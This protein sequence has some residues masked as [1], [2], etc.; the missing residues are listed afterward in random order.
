[1]K[2]STIRAEILGIPRISPRQHASTPGQAW[3][4]GCQAMREASSGKGR[5]VELI[6]PLSIELPGRV[7]APLRLCEGRSPGGSGKSG[8][9][10]RSSRWLCDDQPR[11]QPLHEPGLGP[12]A[13][14]FGS[15]L[16]SYKPSAIV[17][18]SVGQRGGA[19]AAV[20]MRTFLSELGC[21]PVSAMI[22]L[23][24]TQDILAETGDFAAGVDAAA[25]HGYFGRT[26]AQLEWW[27]AAA[28]ARRAL[29]AY[30]PLRPPSA[31][32]LLS[33][34]PLD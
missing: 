34:M 5:A 14:H 31:A 6:D 16:F 20:N 32:I 19:R 29:K 23:P 18:Y 12:P 22:R 9:E 15:S 8:W 13:N 1:M 17:T 24:K 26:F 7:Q 33:G 11:V 28:G 4:S 3:L 21:L 10:D 25:W 30:Q 27:A 2:E